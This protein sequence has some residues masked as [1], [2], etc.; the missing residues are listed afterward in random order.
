ML[1][2]QR[3]RARLKDPSP[4]RED[5]TATDLEGIVS[6]AKG[7]AAVVSF[8]GFPV[9]NDAQIAALEGRKL[10][11][12]AIYSAG[13]KAGTH[14]KK[15]L[16]AKALDVAVLPRLDPSANAAPNST[17]ARDIFNQRYK[18]VTPDTVA[19]TSF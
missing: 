17:A 13:P 11:F 18:L 2:T 12:I 7:V 4:T 14:Y 6:G 3:V 16:T 5:L 19:Q 1:A 8:V 15:L 10:K 9:L